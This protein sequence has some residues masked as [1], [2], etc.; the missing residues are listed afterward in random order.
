MESNQIHTELE[1]L[2]LEFQYFSHGSSLGNSSF[3]QMELEFPRLEFHFFFFWSMS[4]FIQEK[5]G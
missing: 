5:M 3:V 2:K 4:D 1:S